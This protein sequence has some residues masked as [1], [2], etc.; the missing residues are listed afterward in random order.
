LYVGKKPDED[1]TGVMF[2]YNLLLTFLTPSGGGPSQTFSV[3][4]TGALNG[5]MAYVELSGLDLLFT[6]PLELS[7]VKLSNFHFVA[8]DDGTGSSVFSGNTWTAKDDQTTAYLYLVADVAATA[9]PNPDPD[10]SAVP[11]PSTLTLFGIGLLGLTTLRRR[12]ARG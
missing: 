11:E 5:S 2:D 6:D 12:K 7:G 10:P 1:Q 9:I 3:G 4:I 8:V